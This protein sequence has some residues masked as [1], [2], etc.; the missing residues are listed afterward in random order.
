MGFLFNKLLIFFSNTLQVLSQEQI[1]LKHF[2]DCN[3]PKYSTWVPSNCGHEELPI[4]A[5]GEFMVK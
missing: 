5:D 1:G 2:K 4:R 3:F